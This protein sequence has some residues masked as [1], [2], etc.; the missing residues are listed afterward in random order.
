MS[1]PNQLLCLSPLVLISLAACGLFQPS[2]RGQEPSATVA[3]A[4]LPSSDRV[5]T[6]GG[7]WDAN[8]EEWRGPCASGDIGYEGAQEASVKFDRSMSEK[9]TASALGF[10]LNARA[11]YGVYDGDLAASFA[12]EASSSAFS[13]SATYSALYKFK[14]AKLKNAALSTVGKTAWE[15]GP[16]SFTKTCGHEYV[17]QLQL[18]ARFMVNIKMEFSSK[19]EK[20]NFSANIGLR[21]PAFSVRA[22]L[23]QASQSLS[24]S[25]SVSIRLFQQGGNISRIT[26]ALTGLDVPINLDDKS[27]TASAVVVCSME[28]I[29]ACLK[30]IDGAVKYATDTKALGSFP[31]QINFD[32]LDLT[33]PSG[34]AILGYITAPWTDLAVY[35]PDPFTEANVL[36]ARKQLFDAFEKQLGYANRI[37]AVLAGPIRLSPAQNVAFDDK[38]KTIYANI[39][40][41]VE[42]GKT[43]FVAISKCGESKTDA[44]SNNNPNHLDE[45]FDVLPTTFAQWCDISNL[46]VHRLSMKRT[47]TELLTVA[48][49]DLNSLGADPCGA[50][51]SALVDLKKID[52]AGKG[53]TNIQPIAALPKV[54]WLSLKG[55]EI[56]DIAPLASM[57]TLSYLDVSFNRFLDVKPLSALSGLRTLRAHGNA[58]DDSKPVRNLFKPLSQLFLNDAEVCA[59]SRQQAVDVGVISAQEFQYYTKIDWA[60]A[61]AKAGDPS[62]GITAWGDCD[63][64]VS[65]LL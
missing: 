35:P 24:R 12:R 38:K 32:K 25:A 46:P 10:S 64:A 17:D 57:T 53:L 1:V 22:K 50:A 49:L 18:G 7:G 8:M 37:D 54:A 2:H 63:I 33:S 59:F 40:A 27:Q 44:L 65:Q 55:N 62:S 11:R 41:I 4:R 43:C 34:P 36:S 20:Q 13:E 14:N 29:D 60:P 42:A 21:G 16:E 26:S 47:V 31:D 61:Y 23:E 45:D 48:Q 3:S 5:G 56:E 19:A 39:D 30:V 51:G 52:L 15:R 28:R 9:E 58:I 6:I